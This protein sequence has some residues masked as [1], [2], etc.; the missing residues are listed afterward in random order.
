MTRETMLHK[1][2]SLPGF[3]RSPVIGM[4]VR[5]HQGSFCLSPEKARDRRVLIIG[6]ARTVEDDLSQ[7]EAARYDTIVKLNNGLD[8]PIR[9]E[10]LASLRCVP[11]SQPD[12][13]GAPGDR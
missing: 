6:P 10:G 8:T 1:L 5:R 4:L 12:R 3:L 11:V 13:R 2:C 9:A 7:I